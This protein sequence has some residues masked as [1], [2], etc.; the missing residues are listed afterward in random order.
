MLA[1][2]NGADQ[3]AHPRSLFSALVIR[4]Q[5][6]KV[7]RFDISLF[8]ILFDG[9]K[10]D[11]APGYAPAYAPGY[12]PGYAPGSQKYDEAFNVPCSQVTLSVYEAGVY[13][14]WSPAF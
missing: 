13:T 11:E 10:H 7:T 12:T 1:N 4:F 6:S 3:P 8:S 9:L 14:W 2:N 5:K